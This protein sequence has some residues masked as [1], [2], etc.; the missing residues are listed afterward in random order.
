MR[1]V[2][3]VFGECSRVEFF[4]CVAHT[5][6]LSAMVTFDLEVCALHSEGVFFQL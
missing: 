5:T 6:A 1:Y 4:K 2:H 3:M